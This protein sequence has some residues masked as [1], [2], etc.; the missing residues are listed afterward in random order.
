MRSLARGRPRLGQRAAAWLRGSWHDAWRPR[1]RFEDAHVQHRRRLDTTGRAGAARHYRTAIRRR[2][3]DNAEWV[4]P[5]EWLD[6]RP[7]DA[8]RTG[9][10]AC[11][12]ASTAP[13]SSARSSPSSVSPTTS[14]STTASNRPPWGTSTSSARRCRHCTTT[15]PGLSRTCRPTRA[16]RAST[17][18]GWSRSS[19]AISTTSS[20]CRIPYRDDLAAKI[21]DA[22][23]KAKVPQGITQKLTAIR[24]IANTAVHENRQIRPDVS[25]AVLRELFHVV[26]WTSYHHSPRPESGA[27]AGP[28]RPGARSQSRAAVA[29][30]GRPARCEVQGAGRGPR[31]RAG[32]RRT[33]DWPPTRPRSPS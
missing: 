10:R 15:A 2:D 33:S 17:A 32:A 21:N 27:A 16:R 24:R 18:A 5:V 20:R 23:F 30:G 31:P 26:V 28:V 29:R 13:A 9:R 7:L 25:L 11:S 6:A 1:T 14:T 8:R 4:V 19:S 22:A 3:D 12:P